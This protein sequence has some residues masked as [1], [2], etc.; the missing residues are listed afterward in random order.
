M[1]IW[2]AGGIFMVAF[3]GWIAYSYLKMKNAPP[4]ADHPHVKNLTQNNF[5]QYTAVGLVLVDFWAPWCGPCK[6]IAPVLEEIAQSYID[7]L[8][9]VKVNV[10]DSQATA[11]KYGIRSIP[12]LLVIKAGQV[13]GTRVGSLPKAQLT[14]FI[15]EL[16]K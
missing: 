2:I 14:Q 13:M 4:A 7:K 12:T 1:N 15:D 8:D 3:V 9:I 6:A 5:K 10:D 11:A 16:I